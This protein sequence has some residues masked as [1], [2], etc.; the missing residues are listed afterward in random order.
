MQLQSQESGV[1]SLLSSYY[2]RPIDIAV[3]GYRGTVSI[4][5]NQS[6][7]MAGR[8]MG[9]SRLGLGGRRRVDIRAEERGRMRQGRNRKANGVGGRG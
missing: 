2:A 5:T 3:D 1:R 9:I 7:V 4:S 6:T 8:V